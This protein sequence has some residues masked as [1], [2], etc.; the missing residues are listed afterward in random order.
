VRG[1]PIR[2]FAIPILAKLPDVSRFSAK[3]PYVSSSRP[4]GPYGRGTFAMKLTLNVLAAPPLDP[5]AAPANFGPC[6]SSI[7]KLVAEYAGRRAQLPSTLPSSGPECNDL[8]TALR[9]VLMEQEKDYMAAEALNFTAGS[10]EALESRANDA[11]GALSIV[12]RRDEFAELPLDTAMPKLAAS[13]DAAATAGRDHRKKVSVPT[14]LTGSEKVGSLRDEELRQTT[15]ELIKAKY[16]LA[17][18]ALNSEWVVA[19][20]LSSGQGGASTL[21]PKLKGHGEAEK[22]LIFRKQSDALIGEAL[23]NK[24]WQDAAREIAVDALLDADSPSSSELR[25]AAELRQSAADQFTVLIQR[26][27]REKATQ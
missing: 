26:L 24:Q 8:Y 1:R 19:S 13:L 22:A 27:L 16:L 6:L 25:K 10:A 3:V 17:P 18:D 5:E 21:P 20:T 2:D 23:S 12:A 11:Y 14:G 4:L 7:Y 15:I 9:P